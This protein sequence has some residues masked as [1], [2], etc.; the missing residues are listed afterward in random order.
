MAEILELSDK[1]FF[2]TMVN[3]LRALKEKVDNVPEQR[4]H[5]SRRLG[6]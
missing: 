3:I 4:G 1:E 5:V 2:K 6:L